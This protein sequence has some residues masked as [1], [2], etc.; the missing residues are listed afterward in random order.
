MRKKI[1]II[2]SAV[3]SL[4]S[5]GLIRELARHGVEVIGIDAALLS[6]GFHVLAKGYVVPKGDS[7]GFI[8][9][10]LKIIDTERPDAIISGPESELLTLS[11]NKRDIEQRGALLLCPDYKYV[12]IC[13]DKMKTYEAFRTLNIPYPGL[14]IERKVKFPCVVKPRIGRG[15]LG[16]Y[17][18]R[19]EKELDFYV[20]MVKEPIIQEFI[21][22]R[23]Y[24]IDMLTDKN[25]DA[26]SIVPR[27]RLD[28]ESGISTKGVTVYD[29]E[30]I[31]YCRKIA[32]HLKLFG[33]SCIQ[34]IRDVKGLKFIE[35]NARFGGGSI[36]SMKSD[37]SIIPNLI[38]MIKRERPCPSKGFK[39]GLVMLRNYSEVILSETKAKKIQ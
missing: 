31:T 33:P 23:E 16:V 18:A 38:K 22:G 36:L 15:S 32:K 3:G 9:S 39:E 19:S 37:P 17:I 13:A 30:I 4:P 25:G 27:L 7:P 2:R 8:Q 10:I 34:C 21:K 28:V 1:K 35:V 6:F 11:K 5:L 14:Y 26:L 20:D 12:S 24:S 29:K